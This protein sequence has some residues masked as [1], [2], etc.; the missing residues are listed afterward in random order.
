MLNHLVVGTP[1]L[2][3]R[4]LSADYPSQKAYVSFVVRDK[5]IQLGKPSDTLIARKWILAQQ[6][7]N[8]FAI[9]YVQ[10]TLFVECSL[11]ITKSQRL[12]LQ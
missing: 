7:R 8:I 3:L 2:E 10:R 5:R 4:V 6:S 9:G 12:S 11:M 1:V